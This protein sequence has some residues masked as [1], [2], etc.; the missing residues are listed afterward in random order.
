MK[1]YTPGPVRRGGSAIRCKTYSGQQGVLFILFHLPLAHAIYPQS[2]EYTEGVL[3]IDT[4]RA[5]SPAVSADGLI[6]RSELRN[7]RRAAA[8]PLPAELVS[9]GTWPPVDVGE[10]GCD[11]DGDVAD[12]F[13]ARGMITGLSE[14]STELYSGEL[15]HVRAGSGIGGG[16]GDL[17][18]VQDPDL[19]GPAIAEPEA[20]AGADD[21]LIG[22]VPG[23]VSARRGVAAGKG[24]GETEVRDLLG[25][26]DDGRV[27]CPCALRT[28]TGGAAG[29]SGRRLGVRMRMLRE[30]LDD[31][32]LSDAAREG[33]GECERPDRL[34][35][36]VGEGAR[37]GGCGGG[38]DVAS[39]SSSSSGGCSAPSLFCSGSAGS[40]ASRGAAA[41]AKLGDGCCLGPSESVPGSAAG[42]GA[43]WAVHFSSSSVGGGIAA[44]VV[45]SFLPRAR[46]NVGVRVRNFTLRPSGLRLRGRGGACGLDLVAAFRLVFSRTVS[47]SCCTGP[48][49]QPNQTMRSHVTK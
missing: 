34:R 15:A 26:E 20:T 37:A 27:E 14:G 30:G 12:A 16:E 11:S 38:G 24:E 3:C 42:A 35:D 13:F 25:V 41:E 4:W 8:S 5:C 19:D 1:L 6:R 49:S 2:F 45:V 47:L 7:P 40:R 23:D 44:A 46:G 22:G 21:V 31:D 36:A 29:G 39:A 9:A 17:V 33:V 48:V 32:G 43:S 10:V 28:G 18:P